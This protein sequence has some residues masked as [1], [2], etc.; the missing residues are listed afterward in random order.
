[1]KDFLKV[2]KAFYFLCIITIFP[3]NSG[4]ENNQGPKIIYIAII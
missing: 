1:M 3:L 2:H 4:F